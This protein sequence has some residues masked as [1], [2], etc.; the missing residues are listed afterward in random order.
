MT[1][2]RPIDEQAWTSCAK[3]NA[4]QPSIKATPSAEFVKNVNQIRVSHAVAWLTSAIAR[5]HRRHR[6]AEHD[7]DVG[8]RAHQGN[9]HAAGHRLAQ[10]A[11]LRM[12]LGESLVLSITGAIVGQPGGTGPSEAIDPLA[13]CIRTSSAATSPPRSSS[14]AFWWPSWWACSE[15]SIRRCGDAN[16]LPTEAL[17]RNK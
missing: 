8:L 4:L 11:H 13:D 14:R 16:L 7:G 3:I 15:R 10:I 17:R 9:R 1:V 12:V 6:H 2:K 5:F